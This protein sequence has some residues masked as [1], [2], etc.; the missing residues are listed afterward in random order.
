MGV[1]IHAY[2]DPKLVFNEPKKK[3]DKTA[4]LPTT[5]RLF[6]PLKGGGG[7]LAAKR[8]GLG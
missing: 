6:R 2:S 4:Q 8:G 3:Y 7:V 1:G 5:A